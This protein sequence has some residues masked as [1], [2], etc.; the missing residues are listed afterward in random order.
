MTS[1]A[2]S[3]APVSASG[4]TANGADDFY[5]G[6]LPTPKSHAGLLRVLLPIMVLGLGA[7]VAM[8]SSSQPDPGK[9]VWRSE[10][11]S[12]TGTLLTAPWPMVVTSDSGGTTG[13]VVLLV[14]EGKHG[15]QARAAALANRVVTVKGL[16][17]TRDHRVILELVPGPDAITAVDGVSA[18]PP[19]TENLNQT[20]TLTGEIIDSKC[21]HGAMKPG[22]GKTHKACATVCIG[23]GIPAMF[24]ASDGE[25][26]LFAPTEGDGLDEDSL[27]KI[28]EPVEIR[29]S[30]SRLAD[31]RVLTVA[32]GTVR[33]INP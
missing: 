6:Y 33:R 21:Y 28:G 5:V 27:S 17:L 10:I 4:G 16:V 2:S 23:N 30:V 26:Y 1:E 32:P 22:Q 24:L 25:V 29:A 8:V 3:A 14:E 15:A 9:A 20:V 18:V 31:T 12:F 7:L 19:S 13:R 11:E